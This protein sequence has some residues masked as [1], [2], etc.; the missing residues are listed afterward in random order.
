QYEERDVPGLVGDERV[1]HRQDAVEEVPDR[2]AAEKP[3]LE[4]DDPAE[5][6]GHHLLY[7]LRRDAAELAALDLAQLL[8]PLR[9]LRRRDGMC[10][11]ERAGEPARDDAVEG[12]PGEC[13]RGGDRLLAARVREH[14]LVR[15]LALEVAHLRVAHQVDAP[16]RRCRHCARRDCP[17]AACMPPIMPRGAA[18][19]GK[20]S[21]S[22]WSKASASQRSSLA[23]SSP[24]S[25]PC[26]ALIA[27]PQTWNTWPVM[28]CASSAASATTSGDMFAG[29]SGSKPSVGPLMSN[30]SSVIRVRALG[31]R[32]LTVTP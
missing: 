16:A 20:R 30:V 5:R 8:L 13:V 32:Q 24:A 31:A 6:D 11:L 27:P 4:G 25:Q 21:S 2:L 10:R 17:P 29:S 9:L 3:R 7:V 1:D 23:K 22:S 19:S 26:S 18:P 28:C 12:H 14:D 15:V